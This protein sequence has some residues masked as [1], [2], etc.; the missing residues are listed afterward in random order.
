MVV[1]DLL[2]LLM[3]SDGMVIEVPLV[4]INVGSNSLLDDEVI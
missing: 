4:I 3:S 2:L 1:T